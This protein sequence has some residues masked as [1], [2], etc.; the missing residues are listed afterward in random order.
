MK[1]KK[2]TMLAAALVVAV[3]A[4]AGVGYATSYKAT[5]TNDGNDLETTYLVIK[6]T[7]GAAYNL[8]LFK[9]VFFDTET[10]G[11]VSGTEGNYTYGHITKYTPVYDYYLAENSS[12]YVADA[13]TTETCNAALI[14]K[15]LVLSLQKTNS[16]QTTAD[17]RVTVSNF[18]AIEGITYTMILVASS[19]NGN[20]VAYK[21]SDYGAQE[22]VNNEGGWNGWYFSGV[23]I[24][25]AN[26]TDPVTYTVY[27]FLS[28]GAAV[29]EVSTIASAGFNTGTGTDVKSTFTFEATAST[30]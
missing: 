10:T 12:T 5:T 24:G 25:A 4:L 9:A 16:A 7:S 3:V 23:S 18:G 17:L 27:L 6:Q 21:T 28:A 20:I 15:P 19:S 30:S 26:S 13:D 11:T 1:S 22:Q 29:S 2:V 8:D 14:S